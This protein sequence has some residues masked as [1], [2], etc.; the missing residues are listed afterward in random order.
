MRRTSLLCASS[1]LLLACSSPP[2]LDGVGE[3]VAE[4]PPPEPVAAPDSDIYDEAGQLRESDE[5]IAGL[6]VPRGLTKV[7]ELSAPRRHVYVSDVPHTKV[8]RYFGPRLLT[9][10]VEHRGSQVVYEQATP[11]GV[12]GGVVQLDVSIEPTS[13]GTT[14]VEIYERPPPP[15]PGVVI[16]EDEIRRHFRERQR[17]AE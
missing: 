10:Q 16:S 4:A 9:M 8:L 2:S 6:I 1:A 15:P 14:Y 12:R 13:N 17:N 7:A 5:R 11:R 3:V